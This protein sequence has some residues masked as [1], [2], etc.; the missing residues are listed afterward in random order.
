MAPSGRSDEDQRRFFVVVI[1]Y[2]GPRLESS[3]QSPTPSN[4]SDQAWDRCCTQAPTQD[5]ET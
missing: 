5:N 4:A 2:G 1:V 3:Q